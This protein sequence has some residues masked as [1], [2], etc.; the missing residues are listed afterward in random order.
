MVRSIRFYFD[1]ISPYSWL[2]LRKA[3]SFSVQQDVDWELRPVVYAKLLDSTGLIGPAEVDVKRIYTWRDI[4]R[5]AE[6]EGLSFIGP[7]AHPFRSLEALRTQCAFSE[8]DRSLSLAVA[9]AAAAWEQGRD[10]T[11][12]NTIASIVKAVGLPA[13]D[14]ESRITDRTIKDRLREWTT[15]AISDGV[16]GVPSFVHNGEV[17]WGHDRLSQLADAVAGRF[18]TANVLADSMANRPGGA[19]RRNRQETSRDRQADG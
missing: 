8:T 1:F 18:L 15:A 13:E 14:L 12:L 19:V 4:A 7:P 9:L 11:D 6:Q 17:F 5:S 16:F 2:A 10:L 3:K